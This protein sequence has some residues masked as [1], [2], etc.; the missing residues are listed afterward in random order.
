[1]GTLRRSMNRLLS[2][3]HKEPHDS[4]LD[5]EVASHLELAIDENIR[6]GKSP[7]EARR[8]ALIRFGGFICRPLQCVELRGTFAVG[9][10]K[11][12]DSSRIDLG[13]ARREDVGEGA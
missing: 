12:S 6:D 3:F 1:M 13:R 9:A 2:F 5:A 7:Q 4:E 10:L 8:Q 11:L